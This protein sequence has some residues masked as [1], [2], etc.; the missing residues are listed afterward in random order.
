MRCRALSQIMTASIAIT[1]SLAA[2]VL[3]CT[4]TVAQNGESAAKPDHVVT[5]EELQKLYL[6][7]PVAKLPTPRAS[8]GHPDLSGFYYNVLSA[9]GKRNADGTIVFG[10][11]LEATRRRPNTPSR[12]SPLTSLNI[13]QR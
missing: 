12:P 13:L 9:T 8:D 10:L 6:A 1:S 3:F 4:V 7:L 2:L 5:N 11:A